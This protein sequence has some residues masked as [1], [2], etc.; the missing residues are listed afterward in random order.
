VRGALPASGILS[1]WSRGIPNAHYTHEDTGK[2]SAVLA[3]S[4]GAFVI[5]GA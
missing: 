2:M 3:D 4:D 1:R 5:V